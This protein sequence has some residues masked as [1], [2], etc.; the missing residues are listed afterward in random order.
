MPASVSFSRSVLARARDLGDCTVSRDAEGLL[1]Q[2][3]VSSSPE[4]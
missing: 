3:S 4:P 2:T 1:G